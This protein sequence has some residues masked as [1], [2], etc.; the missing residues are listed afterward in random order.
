[1]PGAGKVVGRLPGANRAP[2]CKKWQKL[3]EL[4][5]NW[6]SGWKKLHVKE[7]HSYSLL[8]LQGFHIRG[9]DGD[10]G[11]YHGSNRSQ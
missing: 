7:N 1:M 2:K 6:K 9:K 5:K 10:R 8:F 4:G 11:V 3:L